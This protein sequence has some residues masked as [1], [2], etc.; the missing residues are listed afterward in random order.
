MSKQT[1]PSTGAVVANIVNPSNANFTELYIQKSDLA[2]SSGVIGTV[3]LPSDFVFTTA[4]L[5]IYTGY[6]IEIRFA[7][8][9]GGAIVT[10]PSSS[11]LLFTGGSI[12]NFN[13]LIG[14][15]T[16]I[17]VVGQYKVFDY[18]RSTQVLKGTWSHE[19]WNAAWFG[20]V[21]DGVAIRGNWNPDTDTF[22]P[23]QDNLTDFDIQ[24]SGT[25][26]WDGIQKALDSAYI[27]NITKVYIPNGRYYCASP[28]NMGW[29]GYK[30]MTLRG[31]RDYKIGDVTEFSTTDNG[32]YLLMGTFDYGINVNSGY[33]CV[34]K[35]FAIFGY[36]AMTYRREVAMW[37]NSIDGRNFYPAEPKDWNSP[38]TNDMMQSDGYGLGKYNAYVGLGT[39]AFINWDTIDGG[40]QKRPLP[41]PPVG[42]TFTGSSAKNSTKFRLRRVSVWGFSVGFGMALG[43]FS[44]NCDFYNFYN[45]I[46]K[47]SVYGLTNGS[48]QSRNTGIYDSDF[49]HLQTAIT[50]DRVGG[51]TGNTGTAYYGYCSNTDFDACG[52]LIDVD[53]P[54]AGFYFV[55]AYTENTYKIGIWGEYSDETERA[56]LTFESSKFRLI[57]DE[58]NTLGIPTNYFTGNKLTLLNSSIQNENGVIFTLMARH[59]TASN[60]FVKIITDDVESGFINNCIMAYR[61][62]SSDVTWSRS[63]LEADK[64]NYS[65]YGGLQK[66]L[67]TNDSSNDTNLIPITNSITFDDTTRELYMNYTALFKDV[68]LGD[69]IGSKIGLNSFSVV[70]ELGTDGGGAYLR[71]YVT[72]GFRKIKNAPDDYSYILDNDMTVGNYDVIYKSIRWFDAPLNVL[73]YTEGANAVFTLEEWDANLVVGYKLY[74]EIDDSIQA[75]KRPLITAI[76]EAAKTVTTDASVTFSRSGKIFGYRISDARDYWT[77][78]PN[79]YD[80]II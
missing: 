9:L 57:A 6:I 19:E 5:A 39:D 16:D 76:D 55:N 74:L 50:D 32:T 33:G 77:T 14:S 70:K 25:D 10:L 12:N 40:Y 49:G 35:D 42:V 59:F 17:N 37:Q 68:R 61:N 15:Q 53:N 30:S 3:V 73:N 56:P 13:E 46:N 69:V 51:T 2:A 62:K 71:S 1:I 45:F 58:N 11:R 44:N 29:A 52:Q 21:A 27:T 65:K 78:L 79:I 72:N 23:G 48:N 34:L 20:L 63:Y 24:Y 18:S 67:P 31:Q 41:T 38:Y 75:D 36:N 66:V 47:A 26:N 28:L 43:N 22:T 7:F 54:Q 60:G 64:L 8:D 80:N 4:N